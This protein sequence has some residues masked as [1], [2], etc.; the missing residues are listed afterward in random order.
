MKIVFMG[1]PEFGVP[2]LNALL[3][4]GLITVETACALSK[5]PQQYR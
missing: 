1:T 5:N 3:D 2:S 4:A